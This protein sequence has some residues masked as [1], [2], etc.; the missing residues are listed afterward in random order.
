MKNFS[1][2]FTDNKNFLIPRIIDTGDIGEWKKN[3]PE[4]WRKK[5]YGNNQ[6]DKKTKVNFPLFFLIESMVSNSFHFIL[7]DER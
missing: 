6:K 3:D 5:N 1:H 2:L 7:D 4:D